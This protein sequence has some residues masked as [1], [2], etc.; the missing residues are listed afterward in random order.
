[1]IRLL[2]TA[3]AGYAIYRISREFL[4]TIPSEFEPMPGT[5]PSTPEAQPAN[6]SGAGRNPR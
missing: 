3:A 1:M 4:D 2:L 6:G 5:P